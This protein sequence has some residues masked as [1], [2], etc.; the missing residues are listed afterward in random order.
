MTEQLI[1]F[2]TAKLAKEKGFNEPSAYVC[3]IGYNSIKEDIEIRPFGNGH[4]N[5]KLFQYVTLSK[6]QPHLALVP[7]QSL[8]Q[9]WLREEY[10]IHLNVFPNLFINDASKIEYKVECTQFFGIEHFETYEQ[11][12]EAGLQKALTLI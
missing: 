10:N 3:T 8:L 5:E 12:L 7:T 6:G 2:E 1:E 4:D 11:A 9:R